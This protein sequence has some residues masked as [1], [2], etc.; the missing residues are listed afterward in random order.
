MSYVCLLSFHKSDEAETICRKKK[1]MK[2]EKK[3]MERGRFKGMK[4]GREKGEERERKG[5][6]KKDNWRRVKS[7]KCLRKVY[8]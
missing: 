1:K 3:G 7:Q 5:G 8:W 6:R 2:K 4:R